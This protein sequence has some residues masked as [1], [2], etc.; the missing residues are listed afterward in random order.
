V[1]KDGWVFFY[2]VV[3]AVAIVVVVDVLGEELVD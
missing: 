1:G 3:G 2:E